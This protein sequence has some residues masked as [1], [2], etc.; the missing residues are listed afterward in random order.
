MFKEFFGKKTS[1]E[2]PDAIVE[3]GVEEKSIDEVT[4]PSET[5]VAYEAVRMGTDANYHIVDP[6][7][8]IPEDGN[9]PEEDK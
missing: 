6:D 8:R 5:Q 7:G 3:N 9:V 4:L 1:P 2:N